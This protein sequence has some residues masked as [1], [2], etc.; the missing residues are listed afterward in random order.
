MKNKTEEIKNKIKNLGPLNINIMLE[1]DIEDVFPIDE[2][3]DEIIESWKEMS[4]TDVLWED[5][6]TWDQWSN[7]ENETFLIKNLVE[8]Y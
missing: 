3:T 2:I 5:H 1:K 6:Y 7:L 8:K 4:E